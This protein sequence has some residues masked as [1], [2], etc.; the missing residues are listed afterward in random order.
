MRYDNCTLAIHLLDTHGCCR[1]VARCDDEALTFTLRTLHEEGQITPMNDVG[2]LDLESCSWLLSPYPATI[3][4]K[5]QEVP[6]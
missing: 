4:G 3:F 6:A 1:E 5:R 2:V